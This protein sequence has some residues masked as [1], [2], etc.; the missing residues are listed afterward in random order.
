M[1]HIGKIKNHIDIELRN[2]MLQLGQIDKNDAWMMSYLKKGHR[3]FL[4]EK[5]NQPVQYWKNVQTRLEN[6][7]NT[8][9]KAKRNRLSHTRRIKKTM[10]ELKLA[11]GTKEFN[12]LQ[13]ESAE[14]WE[15][16]LNKYFKGR[17]ARV[18]NNT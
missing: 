15:N 13:I 14:W 16:K 18:R 4:N 11:L 9:I 6:K 5:V 10:L 8:A 3:A 2:R 12:K 1:N 7:I 17:D